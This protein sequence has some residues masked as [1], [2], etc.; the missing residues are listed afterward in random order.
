LTL[1]KDGVFRT[2]TTA[3]GLTDDVVTEIAEDPEGNLWIGTPLGAVR[4]A[5]GV[6]TKFTTAEGL[7]ENSISAICADSPQGV[8]VATGSTLHRFVNGKFVSLDGA[9]GKT[10]S[11]LDHLANGKD[12]SLWLGFR[13]GEIKQWKAGALTTFNRRDESTQRINQLYADGEGVLW[14]A[15]REGVVQLKDG[16]FEQVP[17]G[18]NNANTGVVYSIFRDREDNVWIGFQSNGLARLRTKQLFTISQLNGL[19][20]D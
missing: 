19:P 1:L 8:F 18:E 16:K 14:V 7:R 2:F 20:N 12:G 17:L 3:D 13:N 6:F 10:S 5:H 4:Y 15:L 11:Q 9:I